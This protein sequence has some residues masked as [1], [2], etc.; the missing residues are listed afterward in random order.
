MSF[1]VVSALTEDNRHIWVCARWAN[2]LEHTRAQNVPGPGPKYPK[3]PSRVRKF[4]GNAH[5]IIGV[6]GHCISPP[7]LNVCATDSA[8]LR[9]LQDEEDE[10]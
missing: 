6:E 8:I 10:D 2:K 7:H 1:A 5:P 4:R 3:A 9:V